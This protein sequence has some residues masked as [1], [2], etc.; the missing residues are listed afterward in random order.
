M[1][2]AVNLRRVSRADSSFVFFEKFSAS[3][4]KHKPW[5]FLWISAEAQ[6][7]LMSAAARTLSLVDLC[8][9]S[10]DATHKMLCEMRW[11][12]T[13][14]APVCPLAAA[15]PFIPIGVVACSN[16]RPAIGSFR[17]RA[18]PCSLTGSF[19]FELYSWP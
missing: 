1:N 19:R 13:D 12:D 11:E 18:A 7:F 3:W 6:H 16:A 10:E 15:L 14:G 17:R 4:R 9:L 2:F 8:E 5:R